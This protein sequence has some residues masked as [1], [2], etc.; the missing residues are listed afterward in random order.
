MEGTNKQK[1][2]KLQKVERRLITTKYAWNV[3]ESSA[4]KMMAA[5][6]DPPT[7]LTRYPN[8]DIGRDHGKGW[9]AATSCMTRRKEGIVSLELGSA[10]SCGN[11]PGF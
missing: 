10:S 4:L 8:D 9:R 11:F 5:D 3:M 7:V 2:L 6:I 1:S